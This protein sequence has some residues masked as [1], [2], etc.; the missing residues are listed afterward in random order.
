M[1]TQGGQELPQIQYSHAIVYSGPLQ[2]PQTQSLRGQLCFLNQPSQPQVGSTHLP[3]TGLLLVF[4]SW[5][6][7]TF[8][9]RSLYGLIRSTKYPI[10]IHVTGNI[11]SAAIPFML[12]ADR[13]SAAPGTT[14]LFHPWTWGTEL[15]PGHTAEGLRQFPL[16]SD[17]DVAWGRRILKQRSLLTDADIDGMQL[18]EK[19]R[20]EDENFALKYGMVHE[21]VER[22]IPL[23]IMTW[24]VT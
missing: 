19:A 23:G 7:N 9:M 18:F 5:G 4:S 6:G 16:Q 3:C 20:I 8:E 15:H 24:N 21:I 22:D 10:E 2:V 11:K 14:F 12:A 1:A 17:D 13:R